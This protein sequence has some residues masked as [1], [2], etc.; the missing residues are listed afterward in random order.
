MSHYWL[1][2]LILVFS[3]RRALGA[4]ASPK[5]NPAGPEGLGPLVPNSDPLSLHML[6]LYEKYSRDG[7][8][9]QDGNTVRSFRAQPDSLVPTPL[10]YF[11]LTSLQQS[12]E[13]LAST[14]HLAPAKVPRSSRDSYCKRTKNSSCRLLM[15]THLQRISLVF[16]SVENNKDLGIIKLN[17]T[18]LSYKRA[19]WHVKDITGIIKEAQFEED[20]FISMEIKFGEKISTIYDNVLSELPYI[21]VFADDRAISDPNSVALGLQRYDPFQAISVD[22]KQTT[23]TSSESRVKR[24]AAFITSSHDNELPDIKY[25]HYNKQELWESPYKSLK[26]KSSRKEKKKKGHDNVETL[27][28]SSVLH[29]DER[30][31]KKARRKQWNEPK[32]CSR[33]YLKVD[34]A[35]IGW[36]EWIISPKSF[37]A[38]YCSGTC[39]FPMPKVVRP[40]N[41]A[42]I[43]SIVKAVGIIPGVPEPC[44]APDRMNHLSVLFLD[45]NR[46]VVL[47][48]Y[49]NMSV[50]SCSCR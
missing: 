21:L 14:L 30:T 23:N 40:S 42:T 28:K 47:K 44:C 33:R 13:I 1:S 2:C 27:P 12:E 37:D 5:Q 8:R 16:R 32:V 46:N 11:N 49:P 45:E 6:K 17:M 35:D 39:E 38:Y 34:F 29:F 15:P 20:L 7:N 26:H 31:M 10:Y 41:H 9:P 24:D 25:I 36:S 19:A 3:L 18:S 50:E 43:Q 4:P 22:S 48:V